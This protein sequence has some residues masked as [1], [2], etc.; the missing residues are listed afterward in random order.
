[1]SPKSSSSSRAFIN[2]NTSKRHIEGAGEMAQWVRAIAALAKDLVCFPICP[3]WLIVIQFQETQ[4]PLLTS[5]GTYK[6]DNA[7]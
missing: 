1:M 2:G 5:A 3:W 7:G 6:H 4:W